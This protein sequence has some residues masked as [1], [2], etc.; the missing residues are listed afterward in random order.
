L[1]D[2]SWEVIDFTDKKTK[3]VLE[4]ITGIDFDSEDHLKKTPARFVKMMRELTTP[5]KFEFTVF[6]SDL[7]EMIVVDNIRFYTLCAHHLLPFYGE[8]HIAYV[9]QGK[10]AG[11]SKFARAVR[12]HA[13]SL[14]VQE[15]LTDNIAG[16]IEHKLD[17]LGVAVV[18][19]AE[20]LCM[21]MRGI[22]SPGAKTT[23]SSMRGVFA[24]HSRQARS[25][26]LS[27]IRKGQV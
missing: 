11:L 12:Y 25:E 4:T 15:Q 3:D 17:P 24:D 8:A 1:T 2:I 7:D 6:E 23:T 18:M 26:F 19:E 20:H 22:R 27:L 13:A 14:N 21:T 16:F 5:E 10:I 9:P